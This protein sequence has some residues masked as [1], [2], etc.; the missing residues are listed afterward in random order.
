MEKANEMAH[1]DN[2]QRSFDDFRIVSAVGKGTYGQI[3]KAID[4]LTRQ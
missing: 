2:A 1:C 3:Y 4:T